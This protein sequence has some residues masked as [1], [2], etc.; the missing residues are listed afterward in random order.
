LTDYQIHELDEEEAD[1]YALFV[2]AIRS[3]NT[4]E[5]YFRRLQRFFEVIESCNG[6]TFEERCNV[7]AKRGRAD[8][9][10]A[11]NNVLRFLQSQKIRAEKKE[12][13]AGTLQNYLKTIKFFCETTDISIP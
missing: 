10:W 3:P 4:K 9:K 13:T 1:P 7:F 8:S 12:I 2:Y 11:F 5:S 6:K